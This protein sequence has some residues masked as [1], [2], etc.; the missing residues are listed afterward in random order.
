MSR[1]YKIAGVVAVLLCMLIF[2]YHFSQ[3]RGAQDASAANRIELPSS[4]PGLHHVVARPEAMPIVDKNAPTDGKRGKSQAPRPEGSSEVKAPTVTFD[5]VAVLPQNDGAGSTATD[6]EP[7]EP[8]AVSADVPTKV[9]AA[10]VSE[11]P[12]S[13]AVN[14]SRP[15][16][17]SPV[18][19]YTVQPND[20]FQSIAIAFYG[21]QGFW[22][23]IAQA[24]PTVDPTK[25]QVGQQIR[26]PSPD[27]M[28]NQ[29]ESEAIAAPGAMVDYT[30]RSGDTL[31]TIAVQYYQD[32]SLW[33]TI[34][35]ANRDRIG[36]DPNRLTAGMKIRIPP[37][38][39]GA[40]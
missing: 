24:N 3:G 33:R 13:P 1:S 40:R 9:A 15:S 26:L 20:S 32:G 7:D 27:Q 25:L 17:E 34:Y 19:L 14:T 22:T 8:T 30:I 5:A 23:D 2:G 39:Q 18:R 38:P 11:Q 35:N 36:S 31:W 28:R 12:V 4:P 21:S 29:T 16:V 37:A 6:G 10:Q